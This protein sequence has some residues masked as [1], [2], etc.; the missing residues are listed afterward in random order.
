MIPLFLAKLGPESEPN[1]YFKHPESESSAGPPILHEGAQVHLLVQL[2]LSS[3]M[4]LNFSA[5]EASV[6][7]PYR[8]GALMRHVTRCAR[9][10]RG[11]LS[12]AS[13]V[14]IPPPPPPLPAPQPIRA[15]KGRMSWHLH[16][17]KPNR[18][19]RS[20]TNQDT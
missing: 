5:V 9:V 14:L 2:H 4:Q 8:A 17:V 3:L 18:P 19:A 13:Y 15:H 20:P 1:S 7:H 11:S 6:E 12:L 10:A 16:Q